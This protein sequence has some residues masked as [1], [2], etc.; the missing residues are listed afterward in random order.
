MKAVKTSTAL[1]ISA[2]ML[3]VALLPSCKGRSS[4]NEVSTAASALSAE[5]STKLHFVMLTDPETQSTTELTTSKATTTKPSTT[6]PT[7]T[8]AATTKPTTTKPATTQPTTA[9]PTTESVPETSETATETT[10]EITTESTTSAPKLSS[11]AE[12]AAAYSS[13]ISQVLSLVNAHRA[14]YG[15][16]PL[17]LDAD[18]TLAACVRAR[19]MAKAGN[20]SHTRPGG[21]S[22]FTVF[23]E[24]GIDCQT[25][26]ENIAYGQSTPQDVF[27]GWRSSPGHNRNMLDSDY[28][29]IGIGVAADEQGRLY[30]VQL[31]ASSVEPIVQA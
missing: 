10:A 1:S 12:N 4:G 3:L 2:L 6:K 16:A 8:K 14:S 7:T 24:V 9:E 28:K 18:M 21:K 25:C 22:C 13:E 31:F 23:K 30:W 29:K 19:E 17:E 15:R 20:L 26:G 11:A 27:S 5:A